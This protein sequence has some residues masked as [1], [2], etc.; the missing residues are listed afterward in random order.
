MEVLFVREMQKLM[1]PELKCR[2][3]H[4]RYSRSSNTYPLQAIC[5]VSHRLR[6][7]K[8]VKVLIHYVEEKSQH[9][10]GRTQSLNRTSLANHVGALMNRK[11]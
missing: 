1:V 9:T 11:A 10:D 7:L 3:H 2:P 4:E 6:Y 8:E 5:P